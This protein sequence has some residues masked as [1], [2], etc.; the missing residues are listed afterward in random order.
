MM[1][2]RNT[3]GTRDPEATPETF[4]AIGEMA[5]VTLVWVKGPKRWEHLSTTETKS[6]E[7]KAMNIE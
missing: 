5:Q 2:V 7:D 6:Y 4:C 3:M 1:N